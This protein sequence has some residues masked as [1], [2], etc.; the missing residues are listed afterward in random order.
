MTIQFFLTLR[1]LFDLNG[2]ND[3]KDDFSVVANFATD[4]SGVAGMSSPS[5]MNFFDASNSDI[6]H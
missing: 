3:L 2:V 1:D 4:F 6:T 5:A